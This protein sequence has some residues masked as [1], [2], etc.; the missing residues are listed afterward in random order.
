MLLRHLYND[1]LAQASYLVGCAATGEA[2]VV[3]PNRDIDRYLALAAREGLRI[4]AVTETHIHADFVSGARELAARTGARLYLSAEGPAEWQYAYA[5][6][7]GA[8][9]VRDGD[10]FM[11]GN[12]RVEV[13]H[14]P[15]H[16]PE[17][18]SFLVTDTAGADAPMG[19]FTGDFVFVGDV[20]RPDLLE[21]AAGYAGTMEAGARD[22]FRSLRRFRDLPEWVQVWPGHGAESAC[23]KALGAVPQ[24]TVG[25]ETRF[26]WAF[27][28]A[29]ERAFVAAVLAG[30]PEPPAYFAQMKRIN[31]EGPAIVGAPDL[32]AA[33]HPGRLLAERQAGTPIIDTRPVAVFAERAIPGTLNI[34]AGASFLTW[35][36]WLLSYDRP[37]AL[38]ADEEALPELVA[39]LRLIGLDHLAGYWIPDAIDAWADEGR[40]LVSIGRTDATGLRDLLAS[41][42]ATVIDVRGA[43]EYAAGHIAGGVN[44]PLGSLARRLDA[45]P[46]FGTVVVQCQ[47]GVRSAIAASLLAAHGRHN[48]RDLA[49]GLDAWRAAGLTVERALG[50]ERLA[51]AR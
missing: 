50:D 29:D 47:S 3:D 2:L 21:R 28:S 12:I 8:T 18:L 42:A 20:G 33:W 19:I 38:I 48:V 22:L 23:G 35:A 1:Q 26:N 7:A 13:W 30:Q 40:E 17:H 43:A 49:G 10:R 31:K 4:V 39:Q 51:L 41:G 46:V 24:T 15:G 25:Y 11:V 45:V 9:L 6:G 5:A 14:T 34:P 16:T 44:I 36:G 27:G 32:P 37:F